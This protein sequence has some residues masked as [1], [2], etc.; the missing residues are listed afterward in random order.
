MKTVSAGTKR[1]PPPTPTRPPA[2]PPAMQTRTA[3][4]SFIGGPPRRSSF[5][6]QVDRHGDQEGGEEVGD[7]A[8]RDPLLDC[9]AEDDAAH[10]GDRQQQAGGDVDVAV[11]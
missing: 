5:E 2:R 8:L 10:G 6:D 7:G 1:T 4:T 3:R 9:G 11:E